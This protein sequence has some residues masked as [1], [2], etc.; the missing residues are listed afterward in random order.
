M[1]CFKSEGAQEVLE[2]L[3]N[4]DL[5]KESEDGES[6]KQDQIMQ[7]GTSWT[8]RLRTRARGGSYRCG[9]HQEKWWNSDEK[10]RVEMEGEMSQGQL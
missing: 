6:W 2:G 5:Q 4:K 7:L 3:E 1:F 9:K 8:R 10:P